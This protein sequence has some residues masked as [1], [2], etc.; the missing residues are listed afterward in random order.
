MND[1]AKKLLL[2]LAAAGAL[3]ADM[4][5]QEFLYKDPRIMGMGA[6]NTAV[7]GYST[8]VFYNPAGLI[9]I[10]K[11]HGVEVELLGISAAASKN[12]KSLMDD[13]DNAQTDAETI[14]AIQKHSG[15]IDNVTASNY[16]SFSY[17]TE[18]DIAFSLG[19]LASADFTFIPH[20]Y[21]GANGLLETHSRIYGGIVGGVAK[22]YSGVL[23]GKLTVGLGAKYITQ[24]SYE[25]GL[26]TAEVTENKDDLITYIMDTYE[27][28]NSGFGI[29]VGILYEPGFL[30][31]LHPAI[32]VS[33]LNIGTL[34]FEDAY[35]AQPMTLNAGVSIAPEVPWV[36]SFKIAVDYVDILNAQ[37][38]RVRN[39]NPYRSDDQY[40]SVDIEFDP[41][42]HIRAGVS[43]GVVDNSW[44]LLTL[45]GGLYQ[46]AYTAGVD[47]QF[48]L[49]KV[50]AAT[51]QEQLG[52]VVGQL[53]D[54]RY[55][56]GVGIGW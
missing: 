4:S 51:Y 39:Y 33:V 42:Q 15:E 13:L 35:G 43:L 30:E 28:D 44:V 47:M 17:H 22:K 19:L 41:L 12:I 7:G 9:N 53:E 18:D 21:S 54:R 8:A 20:A 10:K 56:V 46:G 24:K 32:G 55:M 36:D 14:E 37:Q 23:G 3:Q 11:S 45:M 27:V 25:A 16:T 34:D 48:T 2:S 50:Q 1:T 26:D 5:V 6:A 52:S 29:D 31:S 40:D 49:I 38:A